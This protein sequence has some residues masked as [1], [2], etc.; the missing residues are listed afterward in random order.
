MVS[1]YSVV[2]YVPD[3]IAGERIN[4][5]VVAFGDDTVLSRFADGWELR[6]KR[7]GK[8]GDTSYLREFVEQLQSADKTMFLDFWGEQRINEKDIRRMSEEWRGSIQL[9]KPRAST[10]TPLALLKGVADKFIRAKSSPAPFRTRLQGTHAA[11]WAL[12]GA[13]DAIAGGKDELERL[14]HRNVPIEGRLDHHEADVGI[15]NGGVLHGTWV[16]SFDIG[17]P[18]KVEHDVKR[19]LWTVDDIRKINKDLPISVLMLLPKHHPHGGLMKDASRMFDGLGAEVVEE[20][21]L[22]TWA[23]S[24]VEHVL[25]AGFRTYSA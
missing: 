23:K 22:L 4:I 1:Y 2:Q 20:G 25:P 24:T 16:L 21:S 15:K 17:D 3:P 11:T 18:I 9:T 7:F 6:A 13:I 5:G 10:E 14:V 8:E 19:T 12:R